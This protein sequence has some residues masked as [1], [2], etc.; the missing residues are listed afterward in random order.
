MFGLLFQDNFLQSSIKKPCGCWLELI[1]QS[2]LKIC[3][4]EEIK[5]NLQITTKY[6]SLIWLVPQAACLIL[7]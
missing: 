5:K 6:S 7:H 3:F 1:W 2:A 4:Y